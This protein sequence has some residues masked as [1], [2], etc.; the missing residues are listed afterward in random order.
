MLL[1]VCVSS[2]SKIEKRPL[3]VLFISG[4]RNV[5]CACI[6]TGTVCCERRRQWSAV[7][8]NLFLLGSNLRDDTER[9]YFFKDFDWDLFSEILRHISGSLFCDETVLQVEQLWVQKPWCTYS[10]VQC[11]VFSFCYQVSVDVVFFV[12][13]FLLLAMACVS[14][15]LLHSTSATN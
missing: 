10:S 13:S 5:E 6:G 7:S 14:F 1:F 11:D 15:Q 8:S 2:Y 3:L 12:T 9:D 4:E